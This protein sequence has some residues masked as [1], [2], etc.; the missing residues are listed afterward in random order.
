METRL[1]SNLKF[2]ARQVLCDAINEDQLE[3]RDN[4]WAFKRAVEKYRD[5]LPASNKKWTNEQHLLMATFN[6]VLHAEHIEN[7]S[8][9]YD[10][11]G[12]EREIPKFH[13]VT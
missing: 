13:W 6:D 2:W 8:G 1:S 11:D 3:L 7:W 9:M 12:Y 5:T 10:S 4:Y